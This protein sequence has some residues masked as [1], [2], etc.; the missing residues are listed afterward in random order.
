MLIYRKLFKNI[1]LIF[2]I[3]KKIKRKLVFNYINSI[4]INIILFFEVTSYLIFL[5]FLK[6]QFKN[7]IILKNFSLFNKYLNN[8]SIFYIYILLFFILF[9]MSCTNKAP[10]LFGLLLFTIIKFRL[11]AEE[12]NDCL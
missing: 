5:W 1:N 9:L 12:L 6:Y 3:E 11:L 10:I 7:K 2:L 8:I 4:F